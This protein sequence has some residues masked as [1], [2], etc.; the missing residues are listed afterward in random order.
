MDDF[1]KNKI[2]FNKII[3]NKYKIKKDPDEKNILFIIN[4]EKN[5]KCKYILFMIEKVIHINKNDEDLS[6]SIIIWSDSNPYIDI[7]TQQVSHNIR[8]KLLNTN[9]NLINNSNQLILKKDLNNLIKFMIKNQ[10]NFTIDE[11][12]IYCQWII[13]NN[14]NNIVEYLMITDIIYY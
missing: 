5:I 14:L 13:T 10:T 11:S 6:K 3:T 2:I 12:N 8:S 7:Y 9:N 1:T 4:E